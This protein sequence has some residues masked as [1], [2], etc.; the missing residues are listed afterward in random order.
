MRRRLTRGS[1]TVEASM[2][3]PFIILVLFVFLC[4]CL[5][6][7]DRSVLSSCAAELAGKIERI[8]VT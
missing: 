8:D 4:L 3:I 7:H 5:Y 1:F 2:L 6:L